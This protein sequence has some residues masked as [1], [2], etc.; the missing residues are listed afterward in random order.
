MLLAPEGKPYKNEYD[1]TNFDELIKNPDKFFFFNDNYFWNKLE[2][3]IS[4]MI[5][6]IKNK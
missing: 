5:F 2:K 3:L 6:Y 4:A 1:E